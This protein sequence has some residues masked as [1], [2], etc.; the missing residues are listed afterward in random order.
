MFARLMTTAVAVAALAVG[1]LTGTASA[2]PSGTSGAIPEAARM[3]KTTTGTS[4]VVPLD[5]QEYVQRAAKAGVTL[6]QADLAAISPATVACWAW[7]AWQ[8]GSNVFGNTLWKTHHR[9]NWCGDWSWI[10]DHAYVDRWGETFFP[11]WG[12]KGIEQQGERYG[13]N[14]N[15]YNSWTQRKFCLVQYFDCVQE[16]HPYANVTV[17]PNGAG[18]WN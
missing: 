16:A 9:V 5:K 14:W 1:T 17:W 12:D 11:G 6:S 18:N 2:A 13:V 3:V 10:R 15:Q 7:D 4:P 8:S